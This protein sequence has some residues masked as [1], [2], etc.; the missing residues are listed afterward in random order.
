MRTI[1][2][3]TIFRHLGGWQAQANL[4]VIVGMYDK[5]LLSVHKFSVLIMIIRLL[6]ICCFSL[7]FALEDPLI[8]RVFTS[9]QSDDSPNNSSFPGLTQALSFVSPLANVQLQLLSAEGQYRIS[10]PIQVNG[11]VEVVASGQVIEVSRTVTVQLGAVLKLS[12]AV[13][14]A[15]SSSELARAFEVVG[16]CVF[17]AVSIENFGVPLV[18]LSGNFTLVESLDKGS[19]A[20]VISITAASSSIELAS[21]YVTN[22]AGPFLLTPAKGSQTL[23]FILSAIN[24]TFVANQLSK[25]RSLF[26]VQG[27]AGKMH[28]LDCGYRG[29]LRGLMFFDSARL[30]VSFVNVI[31]TENEDSLVAGY[32]GD[33]IIQFIGCL[34]SGNFGISINFFQ[35]DGQFDFIQSNLTRQKGKGP[36]SLVNS[37]PSAPCVLTLHSAVFADFNLS[38]SEPSPGAFSLL[39][40][41]AIMVEVQVTNVLVSSPVFSNIRSLFFVQ[42][43]GISLIN[44]TMENSGSSGFFLAVFIG[45]LSMQNFQLV[46]PYSGA[47]LYVLCAN[48]AAKVQSGYVTGGSTFV[49][50]GYSVYV[51]RPAYI[52]FLQATSFVANLTFLQPLELMGPFIGFQFSN[53]T[54]TDIFAKGFMTHNYLAVLQSTA[55]A[56]NIYGENIAF[57]MN[58]IAIT[59]SQVVLR[60]VTFVNCRCLVPNLGL[61]WVMHNS[62]ITVQGLVVRNTSASGFLKTPFSALTLSDVLIEKCKF[63]ILIQYTC[64]SQISFQRLSLLHTET[65][66]V[67]DINS[68][69]SFNDATILSLTSSRLL[70]VGFGTRLT[71]HNVTVL[72]LHSSQALGKFTQ[73]SS[74]IFRNCEFHTIST[75]DQIGWQIWE[76]QLDI[77]DSSF[78]HVE[79]ALF[80]GITTNISIARASFLHI[81]NPTLSLFSRA[82]YGGVLGCLNCPQVSIHEAEIVNATSKVGGGFAFRSDSTQEPTRLSIIGSYFQKCRATRAGALFI[83]NAAY[84]ISNCRFLDNAADTVGGAMEVSTKPPHSSMVFNSTFAGNNATEGGAVKWSNAQVYF[85]QVTFSANSAVYGP[86]VA[87]YGV[88]L[89]SALTQLTG[90][91]VSG[92]PLK[93]VFELWDHYSQ[94]VTLGSVKSLRLTTTQALTYSGNEVALLNKGFFNFTGITLYA[95]PGVKHVV[96]ANLQ[97]TQGDYSLSIAGKIILP[98]RNCTSGEIYRKDQC[99]YCF[100]GNVSFSPEDEACTVCPENA[101]CAGGNKLSVNEGYWA[102]Q[103]STELQRCP[104][105]SKC[106]GGELSSCAPGFTGQLCTQCES[107]AFRVRVVECVTCWPLAGLIGQLCVP[108]LLYL[109]YLFAILRF[110]QHPARLFTVKTMITHLQLLYLMSY[111]RI[112]FPPHITYFLHGVSYCASL[113]VTDLPLRC[114]GVEVPEYG[115]AI[116]GSLLL[117]CLVAV[118]VGVCSLLRKSWK[119]RAL[120]LSTSSLLF[121]PLV[122][123]QTLLPLLVCKSVDSTELLFQDMSQ[124][125]WQ[126]WHLKTVLI[127]V[128]PSFLINVFLPL[129]T[130]LV[131]SWLRPGTFAQYFPLWTCGY[132]YP[133]TEAILCTCR[134]LLMTVV[135]L[136][137]QENNLVQIAYLFSVLISVCVVL[138][139]LNKWVCSHG[140]YFAATEASLVITGLSTGFLS[141]FFLPESKNSIAAH[142]FSSAAI[143][144]NIAY[145]GCCAYVLASRQVRVPKYE[146]PSYL[147]S[148][149]PAC[150]EVVPPPNSLQS[151]ANSFHEA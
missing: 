108:L 147:S 21:T 35:F 95:E 122:T 46:N 131:L 142:I 105:P 141:Y 148:M 146:P 54:M 104:L 11:H 31:F 15:N 71:L 16:R 12:G 126:S 4:S 90:Q 106:Q 83:Q 130:I 23:P 145:V 137:I 45:E 57:D 109:A 36:I 37:Q 117:P 6:A 18:W 5:S 55:V 9:A 27:M 144:L 99:V 76:G 47:G 58:P 136:A 25:G 52:V 133:S 100:S 119:R 101:F 116:V 149:E 86:D 97:D 77:S 60:N 73:N 91:E 107:S 94:R 65:A 82:A 125:C 62:E 63:D 85:T 150:S 61:F 143:A 13:L 129:A 30:Q 139:T 98:L 74:L 111:L 78:R 40:C 88:A 134:S 7:V 50:P 72:D 67:F 66:L 33:S 20:E 28:F 19:L 114:F 10:L 49:A 92:V 112:S 44:T 29:N 22:L 124:V 51:E 68:T 17:E 123:I 43:G 69:L 41:F 127:L 79:L 96:E 53:C 128:L 34:L 132:K 93:L 118:H 115:K 120:V 138:A 42:S 102:T 38:V 56:V 110:S 89:S 87:S 140:A 1:S 8:F 103:Q 24:C 26:E 39:F 32:L 3:W 75:A 14:R 81:R 113:L 59:M 151:S 70:M 135:I 121:T 48:G 64:N 2:E 80:Q 84:V